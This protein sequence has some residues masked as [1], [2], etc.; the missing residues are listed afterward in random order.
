MTTLFCV[1]GSGQGF[2]AGVSLEGAVIM[3]RPDVNRKFYGCDVP[4][5]ELLGGL[6]PRPP[7]ADPL[8]GTLQ[9]AVEHG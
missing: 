3:A 4:I 7:A 6:T 5:K 8:Y 9:N 2:F 1:N